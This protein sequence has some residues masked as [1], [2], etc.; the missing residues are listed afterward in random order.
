[1][2]HLFGSFEIKKCIFSHLS[3]INSIQIPIAE[4]AVQLTNGENRLIMPS[5][6][7]IRVLHKINSFTIGDFEEEKVRWQ[8]QRKQKL[9]PQ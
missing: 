4:K 1:M 7:D 8:L 3:G 2:E 9:R 5:I 6:I